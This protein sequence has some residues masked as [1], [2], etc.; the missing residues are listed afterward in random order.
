[1][2][3]NID[4]KKFLSSHDLKWSR[5]PKN[6]EESA[7]L[8][9]G[10]LGAYVY[11]NFNT[12]SLHIELGR[13]DIY[14]NSPS[15]THRLLIGNFELPLK[16]NIKTFKM[17]LNI[18]QAE[19]T[20]KIITDRG[21]VIFSII[22]H[23]KEM[24]IIADTKA[25]QNENGTDFIFTPAEAVSPRQLF[26]LKNNL[27]Y[28]INK[29]YIYHNPAVVT[30]RKNGGQSIQLLSNQLATIVAWNVV[31]ENKHSTLFATIER[32]YLENNPVQKAV[33][34]VNL[35]YCLRDLYKEHYDWWESYYPRSFVSLPDKKLEGLYWIQMYKLASATRE[36]RHLIDVIGPWLTITPWPTAWWNLNVQLT[37]WPC[38]TSNRI[39]LSKSLSNTLVNNMQNMINSVVEEYR[40]D[41]IGIGTAA[42][43]DMKSV[44]A[45]AG[46]NQFKGLKEIGNLTWVMHNC[47]LCYK[48][49]MDDKYLYEVV[50]PILRR[51][52]NY[53]VHFLYK[54]DDNKWHLLKTASPE[55]GVETEDTN[56]ELSLLRW[57]CET[58][59]YI[60]KRLNIND[61]KEDVWN[62][63]L[64]NLAD[65]PKD[66]NGYMIGD[67]QAYTYSHRHPSHLFM[68]FPLHLIS[69]D[70][71]QNK[72]I[73]K[74]SVE[75]WLSKKEGLCGFSDTM[76]SMY[77][78][79]ME[80]GDNALKY[81]KKLEHLLLANT[82]YKETG[83]VIE[84]PLS[85]AQAIHDML[86][87]SQNGIIRFF[88][89]I[90]KD[91]STV[92]F[93]GLAAQGG[94]IV[95]GIY[96]GKAQCIAVTSI[97]N[98]KCIVRL[99]NLSD[100]D[101]SDKNITV[102]NETDIRISLK[103]DETIVINAKGYNNDPISS[104]HHYYNKSF[105]FGLK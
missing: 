8:G 21:E 50:Y 77:Y 48:M 74:K 67:N 15:S 3:L 103:K 10:L 79:L 75:W 72:E 51:C 14:D 29:N 11:F 22:V 52:V 71:K 57:G 101:L 31:K 104:C 9:N 6:W 93:Y 12:N 45:I 100:F 78:S 49:T 81:L 64:D 26:G 98:E 94:F 32:G 88:P 25:M 105:R 7:F 28:C 20:G 36:N 91:W 46:D 4:W 66:E 2:N 99:K 68:I 35:Q 62:S 27:D 65:F 34:Y 18:Y 90:P 58:L 55:Y 92:S 33:D 38:Y 97:S 53:Y 76:A 102:L 85:A 41:S 37:Y 16:G 89:A 82:M 73:I 87:Q 44:V 13:S 5:A 83:P 59:K 61:E 54:R 39:E 80:D 24:L 63:I 95:S 19:L 23:T 60:T 43:A 86:I 40:Y 96:D 47:F 84:T 69:W 70:D 30:L 17:R 1:M 42:N 56:Y